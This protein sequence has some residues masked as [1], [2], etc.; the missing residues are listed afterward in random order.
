MTRIAILGGGSWGTA[1]SVVLSRSA[2]SHQIALWVHDSKLAESARRDRENSAY[3]PGIALPEQVRVGDEIGE[4][5]A[6]AQIVLGVMPSAHARA[7]YSA[8]VSNVS[9]RAVFVSATK[10]LEPATHMRASQVIAEVIPSSLDPQIAVL[11]GPAAKWFFCKNIRRRK[12][13][14]NFGP[15]RRTRSRSSIRRRELRA[16]RHR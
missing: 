15:N 8:A 10:G 2:R 6:G 7:V 11:S 14:G 13:V 16:F 9:K 12:R 5:L 4:A 1:L 3:L